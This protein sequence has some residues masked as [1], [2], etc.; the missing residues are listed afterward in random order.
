MQ[1]DVIPGVDDCGDIGWRDGLYNPFEKARSSN[2]ARECDDHALP[3]HLQDIRSVV[4][5]RRTPTKIKYCSAEGKKRRECKFYHQNISGVHG[6]G[7]A[8]ICAATARSTSDPARLPAASSS[9][10]VM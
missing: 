6:R 1:R 3:H 9:C 7:P 4:H 8:K 5:K 10:G 2:A